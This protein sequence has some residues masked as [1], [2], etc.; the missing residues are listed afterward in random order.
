MGRK[1]PPRPWSGTVLPTSGRSEAEIRP[2]DGIDQAEDDVELEDPGREMG[3][4]PI[5]GSRRPHG[6]AKRQACVLVTGQGP[7]L[8]WAQEVVRRSGLTHEQLA[9]LMGVERTTVSGA[10][11]GR[12]HSL[13]GARV[14][15]LSWAIKFAELCGCRLICEFPE[16][17]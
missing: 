4:A 3:R 14:M 13:N 17:R 15:S 7:V 9:T 6:R 11:N 2:L 16:E 12:L 10:V 8:Q 1:P 5:P